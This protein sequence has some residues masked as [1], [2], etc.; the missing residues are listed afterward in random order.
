MKRLI[1]VLLVLVMVFAAVSLVACTPEEPNNDVEETIKGHKDPKNYTYNSYLMLSPSNWNELTYQDNNDTEIMGYI[2]SSFFGY[3]FKFN[4]KGEIIPGEFTMKY[5]AATKLEDVTSKYVGDKWNIGEDETARAWK[6]TLRNDLKWQNGDPIKAEDFVYTM[7]EQLNPLF[8]NYRA[9]SFYVGATIITNAQGYVKQGQ[10]LETVDNGVSGIYTMADLVKGADGVYTQPDGVAVYFALTEA[11]DWCGGNSVAD[12]AGA[13]YLDATA[14]ASLQA[15]ANEETGRVAITDETIALWTTLIT[16]DA[17]GEDAT[18]LP[19][20]LVYPYT[21]PEMTFDQVGMFVGDNEYEI[22]LVLEKP[23]A[24]LKDDGSLSY[25]AAYNMA[26]LPLVHKATYEACKI[27]PSEGVDLWTTNYNTSVEKTMSWGPY[28]LESYQAGKQHV[29]VRNDQ[30]YG[31]G[32]EENDD[33]YQADRIVCDIVA[34]WNA[35]WVKFQA[36]EVDGISIDVSIAD[37]YKTSDRAYFTPDDFVSSLQ[38]QSSVEGLKARESEGINKSILGYVEFRNAL[39]LAINRAD[40]TQKCTTSSKAGF[41]LYNTMHYYDVANGGVYRNTDDAKKVLC[42]IYGVDPTKYDNLDAAVDSITGYNL[43][44]ARQL[45]ETAY[46]KALA[47]GDIKA[48]DKVKLTFGTGS[49]SEAV[50]RQFEYI[51]NAWVELAKGTSLEGRIELELKDFA[52]AWAEDFRSGAYDVCMGGWTGAAWDPGYFLLAYLSPDY[53]YSAAWDTSSQE[54]TF[55]MKGVGENGADVTETM[56]L[57]EWYNCL[58]GASDAKYNWSSAALEESQR[59]QLIAALEQEVL[60]VYY[61]VPLANNFGA[62]MLSY[63][64]DYVTYEYNTFMGYGGVKYMTFNFDD[65]GW[66]AEVAKNN[67]ELNYK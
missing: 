58:N 33:L 18:Y 22:V 14:F 60:K 8:Q 15:L 54:M 5:E 45:L 65:A 63:K 53:M 4:E 10:S 48:T 34:D 38:L 39:S 35:A 11:L 51:K 56:T 41:G 7:K 61:T 62:S 21:Y 31:Y 20:Y 40:F 43:D 2:G 23:L 64:V 9:D 12:Y 27:E 50:E 30:W 67:G 44:L 59:L 47:A 28:K 57:M 55:T 26:S 1:A 36:G 25:L 52:T 66:T 17:W 16:T 6:I 24:L 49:I 13:G 32:V 3:D 19:N 42:N 29:L 46:D 37:D